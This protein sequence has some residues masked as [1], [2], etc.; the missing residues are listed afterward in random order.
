M[1]K[2]KC[3]KVY[4]LSL[5]FYFEFK[6]NKLMIS[7]KVQFS[8]GFT[9]EH[10]LPFL[11]GFFIFIIIFFLPRQTFGTYPALSGEDLTPNKSFS[12]LALFN[13]M[14]GPLFMLPMITTHLV[15]G[16]ISAGRLQRFFMA[17]EVE[18]QSAG[19]D[20]RERDY[21]STAHGID[22]DYVSSFISS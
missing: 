2:E 10:C 3:A 9:R 17:Q 13:L 21:R 20:W 4:G 18:K 5:R 8:Q 19:N 14:T 22:K 1:S 6:K 7:M 15:N 12:A 16:I 11:L